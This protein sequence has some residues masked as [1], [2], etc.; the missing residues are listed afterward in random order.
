MA[1]HLLGLLTIAAEVSPRRRPCRARYPL[2]QG[3]CSD[4]KRMKPVLAL[5]FLRAAS[6]I[7]QVTNP[8]MVS[9][10]LGAGVDRQIFDP[11]GFSRSVCTTPC[12]NPLQKLSK[13][14]LPGLSG[15]AEQATA[16]SPAVM[17]I[18]TAGAWGGAAI[19]GTAQV[20]A[21]TMIGRMP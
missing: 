9:L 6:A 7:T 2:L 3:Y 1:G 18:L 20:N 19:A 5:S 14:A 12:A 13:A 15:L 17:S 10:R 4:M 16:R 11:P 8:F 21:R